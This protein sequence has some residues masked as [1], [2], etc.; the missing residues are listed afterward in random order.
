MTRA[1]PYVGLEPFS[2]DDAAF[3]FGR[4]QDTRLIVA[5]LRASRL[6]LLYG[7]SG[8]GKSSVLRAGVI[9]GLRGR[10]ETAARKGASRRAPFSITTFGAW[11]DGAPLAALMEA[12]RAATAQA[13]GGD[14]EPWV[15]GTPVT[16][17]LHAWSAEVGTLLVV[18]DQFEE[19]FLYNPDEDLDDEQTFAGAFPA[20]LDDP[21]LPVNVLVALREDAWAKLDRFKGRIPGLF[22]NYLRLEYLKPDAARRAIEGPVEAYN[23]LGGSEPVTIEPGL[24]AAVLNDIAALTP[25]VDGADRTVETPFLQLVM[26]RLWEE[27]V[28]SDSRVLTAG[29][30]R[31]IGG[32]EAIVR[33]HLTRA[34]TDLDAD[35]KAILADVFRFLVTPSGGKIALRISDLAHY[36]DRPSEEI[37]AALERIVGGQR[38]RVLRPVPPA[39]GESE[40][41]Y[42]IFHDVLAEPILEWR[43]EHMQIR[44]Q[45]RLARKLAAEERARAETARRE[46]AARFD[47]LL[48]WSVSGL[49][50]LTAALA[51]AIVFLIRASRQSSARSLAASA[52]VQ[53][54]D[55]PELAVALARRAW[56]K[57]RD[58]D[59]E[60]ALR[61]AAAASR[62]LGGVPV[63]GADV[64]VAARDAAG[65][66][67]VVARGRLRIWDG[68]AGRWLDTVA[69]APG[70][71]I[72]DD[73]AWSA[74]G[75]TVA[76][77]GD[78]RVAVRR[79]SRGARPTF[80]ATENRVTDLALSRDGQALATAE[81]NG[82]RVWST[83]DGRLLASLDRPAGVGAVAFEPRSADILAATTCTEGIVRLWS[84][85]S[86]RRRPLRIG[87]AARPRVRASEAEL[88]CS[89]AFSPDGRWLATARGAGSPV[90]WSVR[91]AA[92]TRRMV[93]IAGPVTRLFW[94]PVGDALGVQAEPG[95]LTLPPHPA[96][97]DEP[98]VDVLIP[99]AASAARGPDA[100]DVLAGAYAPDGRSVAIGLRGGLVLVAD[101]RTGDVELASRVHGRRAV[102]S[103]GF[104]SGHVLAS[105]GADG[106][107]RLLDPAVPTSVRLPT[108]G[109]VAP[110]SVAFSDDGRRVALTTSDG[111]A[112][113]VSVP[114]GELRPIATGR[115]PSAGGIRFA[116]PR[117]VTLLARDPIE[118]GA[119]LIVA[120]ARSA[121]VEQR[122]A[123]PADVVDAQLSPD[124]RR[125]LTLTGAGALMWR[126]LDGRG[127]QRFVWPGASRVVAAALTRDGRRVLAARADGALRVFDA[128]SRRA[129]RDLD[130]RANGLAG[131]LFSPDGRRIAAFSDDHLV[132]VLDVSSGAVMSTLVGHGEAVT[133]ASFSSDGETIATGSLDGSVR[134]WDATTGRPLAV[135]RVHTAE[136]VDVAVDPRDPAVVVTAS[137]DRRAKL[138]RCLTC[139]S[140]DRVLALASRGRRLTPAERARFHG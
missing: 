58:A 77:A 131:A 51:V 83:A 33:E 127:V 124:G 139:G 28:A 42:E 57:D 70:G 115:S 100:V 78:R 97:I 114:G 125:V 136:V 105:A 81:P 7:A 54:A 128:A 61:Q 11:R 122:I 110:T 120:D 95:R 49:L 101:A 107:V 35:S 99:G 60:L 43:R 6:T 27:T 85:R 76:V 89:A 72:G 118:H 113:L 12:I 21:A 45:E 53:L 135:E 22:A 1:S 26:G 138:V 94:S 20:I 31:E 126:E 40:E 121:K 46:H 112:G 5:N 63:A 8:V 55:D 80:V 23:E 90:L 123:L 4:E 106:V 96:D 88:R 117:S 79:A 84:W 64:R 50:V 29:R 111:R 132:R 17:T 98:P 32:A 102:T 91:D 30:L 37:R 39:P 129:I 59:T 133:S 14:L 87:P 3:F 15:P 134:I 75:N 73:I 66:L 47:R 119:R 9:R 36:A 52:L 44:A 19:Y 130:S 103:L 18:L 41:R 92:L 69:V 109:Y 16:A 68:R 48:R 24:A 38:S 56:E 82:A 140:M 86:D 13:S 104:A 67:A 10:L 93:E 2:E 65:L 62:R 108:S 137:K 74:D 34:L 116:G 25:V 71:S